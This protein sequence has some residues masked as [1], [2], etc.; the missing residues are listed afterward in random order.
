M[1]DQT[2]NAKGEGWG[3]GGGGWR[4]EGRGTNKR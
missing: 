4:E 2:L 1:N 3:D